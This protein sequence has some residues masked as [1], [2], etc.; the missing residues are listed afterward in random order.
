MQALITTIANFFQG[1]FGFFTPVI[2]FFVSVGSIVA[3]LLGALADPQGLM[4]QVVCSAIDYVAFIFP[5]TPDNLKIAN[6]INGLGDSIPG[7]GRSVIREIF[8]TITSIF[9]IALVIKIYKLIPF[10]A[11]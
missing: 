6:I 2:V 3:F 8:T 9:G 10:K 4:N 11:T 7:V 5:S 1:L